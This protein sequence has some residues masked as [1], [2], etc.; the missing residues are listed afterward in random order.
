MATIYIYNED[1][2]SIE[3]YE[4]GD[5][6][7][8][9]YVTNHTLT[10]REFRGS[11]CSNVMWTTKSAMHAWNTMRDAYGRAIPLGYAFKRIWEGGHAPQSQHYA[12]VSFDVGQR[13]SNAE[14]NRLR[15]IAANSRVW[16]YVDVATHI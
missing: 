13:L 10:V 3:R 4:L 9:P 7:S 5:H 14:R 11:S 2:N 1:S 8:M 12:G 15:N 6:E 16:S